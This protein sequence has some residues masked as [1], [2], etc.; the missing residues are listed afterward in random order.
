[1]K[2]ELSMEGTSMGHPMLSVIVTAGMYKSSGVSRHFDD[3]RK[4]GH[5]ADF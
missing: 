2:R 5:E 4:G 3:A 1:M